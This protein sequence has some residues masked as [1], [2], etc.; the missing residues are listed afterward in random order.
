MHLVAEV[1]LKAAILLFIFS[2][3]D[4]FDSFNFDAILVNFLSVQELLSPANTWRL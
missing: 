1:S 3:E 2:L 4:I